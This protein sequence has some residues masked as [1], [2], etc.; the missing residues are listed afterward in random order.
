MK[1]RI[2]ISFWIQFFFAI[3]DMITKEK[4]QKLLFIYLFFFLGGGGGGGAGEGD[5]IIL[6]LAVN[7]R[8]KFRTTRYLEKSLT[9]V[10]DKPWKLFCKL[11]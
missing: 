9:T 6:K 11:A 4:I 3:D 10:D 5:K 1:K 2:L 8:T 7:S